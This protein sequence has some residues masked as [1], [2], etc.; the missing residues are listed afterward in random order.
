MLGGPGLRSILKGFVLTLGE[1][2]RRQHDKEALMSLRPDD[3]VDC[4]GRHLSDES[5]RNHETQ[6]A[7]EHLPGRESAFF[8]FL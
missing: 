1:I 3:I 6:E 7:E 5:R 4:L 8:S 2:A